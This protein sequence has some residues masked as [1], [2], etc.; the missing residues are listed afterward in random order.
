MIRKK[1]NR[2]GKEQFIIMQ[3]I[4]L[5]TS[6]SY[7]DYLK[8][9]QKTIVESNSTL[10][11]SNRLLLSSFAKPEEIIIAPLNAN[12]QFSSVSLNLQSIV[13]SQSNEITFEKI[14]VPME[15]N[16]KDVK[17]ITPV[18]NQYSC[19]C[20]WA[21]SIA[22][23]ISDHFICR[24]LFPI[25]PEI[26]MTN[27]ISCYPDSQK[28]NGGNPALALL[29]I[30]QNGLG[31]GNDYY[32]FEWCSESAQCTGK[33][34]ETGQIL[35]EKIPFCN[36]EK[37]SD[38][39]V[40]VENIMSPYPSGNE[41]LNDA[42][43]KS[44][45]E[46]CK[47]KLY[48]FGPTVAGFSVLEN[49]ISGN[50]LC[51]DKNPDNIYLDSV[52][53]KEKKYS[54]TYS[55]YIGGH[56]IVVTGWGQ[57]KVHS[58]LLSMEGTTEEWVQVPYWI[59]RNSWGT[60]WGIDGYFRIAM[61]PFNK[62]SQLDVPVKIVTEVNNERQQVSVGG[63]VFFNIAKYTTVKEKYTSIETY[64]TPPSSSNHQ[65]QYSVIY[66]LI[67]V[68]II[69]VLLFFFLLCFLNLFKALA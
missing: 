50:F 31:L 4:E 51:G 62:K 66:S 64:S 27:L 16:W 69:L 19:G 7:S 9:R 32:N 48:T 55:N 33:A 17:K 28:C 35:N 37:E 34:T 11:D 65:E 30:Q 14:E 49:F 13:S 21:V 59:V 57:G 43:I 23:S 42:W 12:L 44:S 58:S 20:C 54:N 45:I 46:L 26:S 1:K 68:V 24:N 29:W 56:A 8:T 67:I 53:Y 38:F 22:T 41:T 15:W 52:D 3:E 18:Y 47:Q 63:F 2:K 40:Y 36:K 39:R 25:S 60:K 61:Y 5:K 6:Q 10:H